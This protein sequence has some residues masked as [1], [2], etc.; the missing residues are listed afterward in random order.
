M[1][2]A[3]QTL[4]TDKARLITLVLVSAMLTI[5]VFFLIQLALLTSG[6]PELTQQGMMSQSVLDALP[7]FSLVAVFVRPVLL[8]LTLVA[9]LRHWK[10]AL[11]FFLA[12]FAVRITS[13]FMI[14]S[15]TAFELPT[16]FVSLVLE[17]ATIYMFLR[18]PGLR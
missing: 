6:H 11:W 14:V 18:F 7:R 1:P 15:A 2:Q 3:I 12:A 10:I 9:L 13:W 8:I 16:G 17:F 5:P 4:S